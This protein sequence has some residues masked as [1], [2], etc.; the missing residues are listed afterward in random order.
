MQHCAPW[1]SNR[2]TMKVEGVVGQITSKE[3]GLLRSNLTLGTLY[4][5]GGGASYFVA[6]PSYFVAVPS[7]ENT[8][9]WSN[10]VHVQYWGVVPNL[11]LFCKPNAYT[12]KTTWLKLPRVKVSAVSGFTEQN[13]KHSYHQWTPSQPPH[14]PSKFK[15]LAET[16]VC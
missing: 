9:Q 14:N 12:T 6:V 2:D 1:H 5:E 16:L 3:D 10:L 4:F 7:L 11:G 15:E 8:Q 13:Q